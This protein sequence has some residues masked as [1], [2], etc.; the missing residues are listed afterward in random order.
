MGNRILD[1]LAGRREAPPRIEPG[2]LNASPEA[3][4]TNLS[5]PASWLTD[6]ASGTVGG[7][8]GPSVSERTAMACSAVYRSV[9]LLSGI[10]AALM[11]SVIA[12]S[13]ETSLS[14]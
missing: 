11:F 14:R 4:S 2:L 8:F 3:P 10:V 9:S 5:D 13:N 12:K 6:W 1:F 7:S